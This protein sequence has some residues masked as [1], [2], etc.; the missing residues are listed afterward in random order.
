MCEHMQRPVSALLHEFAVCLCSRL[1]R[2]YQPPAGPIQSS[3]SS[4]EHGQQNSYGSCAR[5]CQRLVSALDGRQQT[6]RL[7]CCPVREVH[8]TQRRYC[9]LAAVCRCLGLCHGHSRVRQLQL[10]ASTEHRPQ[11]QQ[12]TGESIWRYKLSGDALFGSSGLGRVREW[13]RADVQRS[14]A[15]QLPSI[16]PA[17]R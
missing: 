11:S 14:Y 10:G 13:A 17:V 9:S 15:G 16:Q 6:G 4:G 1:R 2:R 8:S 7:R 3:H 12:H 5:C